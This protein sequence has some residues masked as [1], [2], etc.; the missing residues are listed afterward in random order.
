MT[1]YGALLQRLGRAR[2]VYVAEKVKNFPAAEHKFERFLARLRGDPGGG[3]ASDKG[4]LAEYFEL[5][6]LYDARQF[7]ALDKDKLDRLSRYMRRFAGAETEQR[8]QAW[9]GGRPQGPKATEASARKSKLVEVEFEAVRLRHNY[10]VFG[11][12]L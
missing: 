3:R 8:Y 10:D 12:V 6:R 2:L 5:R 1:R 9:C 7:V 4:A 11:T